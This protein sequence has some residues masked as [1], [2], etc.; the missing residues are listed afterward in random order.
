MSLDNDHDG[1]C[2]PSDVSPSVSDKL[3]NTNNVIKG[4]EFSYA[5]GRKIAPGRYGA[6]YEVLRKSD[7][8]PFAAKLEVCDLH[9][10]GLNTDYIVLKAANKADCKHFCRL[11]D[12]GKI[13]RHF[14][15]LVMQM[16]GKNLLQLRTEFVDGR[17]S[18]P[19]TLRL[20]LEMLDALEELHSLGYIHRDIK[21]SNFLINEENN[22]T[23]IYISDFGLCRPYKDSE[24]EVK[25]PR[26]KAQFR[27]TT[28][29][30]SLTA[31]NE[32][33]QSPKDDL[34]SWL[35]MIIEFM[36]GD[37]PWNQYSRRD[38]NIVKSLKEHAR[39][40]E[41]AQELLKYCPRMEFRRIMKYIDGLNYHSKPDYNYIRELVHLAQ[42]NYELDPNQPYDW[43]LQLDEE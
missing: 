21:A 40:T 4:Q 18:A 28:R 32:Q 7:G 12:R 37:L 13:E 16:L 1:S 30:A 34:E 3:P 10:H 31:H 43:L 17:F 29:Y 25:Q 2:E 8:K 23:K 36:T 15:F 19:T 33:E 20:A 38:R 22:E 26:E 41:G 5:V 11:I 39:T 24:D 35:Y 42:K 9:F 14:K 27:G 6:V